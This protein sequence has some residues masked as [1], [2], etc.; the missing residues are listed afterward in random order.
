[1]T[2]T[3]KNYW[4]KTDGGR[5][6]FLQ[7]NGMPTDT[8]EV[9]DCVVRAFSIY[10]NEDYAYMYERMDEEQ[11]KPPELGTY[12][13]VYEEIADENGMMLIEFIDTKFKNI[14]EL[15]IN[16]ILRSNPHLATIMNGQIWDNW[17]SGEYEANGIFA[18]ENDYEN[19]WNK[20]KMA[21]IC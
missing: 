11:D 12:D 20:L 4:H 10:L 13:Y 17:D 5:S 7:D 16:G 3:A 18:K 9:G 15:N 6:I 8:E 2:N 21:G 14:A 1:M 19:I